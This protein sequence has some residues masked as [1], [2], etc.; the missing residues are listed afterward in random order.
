MAFRAETPM[1]QIFLPFLIIAVLVGGNRGA[2]AAALALQTETRPK[3]QACLK[4]GIFSDFGQTVIDIA[5]PVITRMYKTAG[6]CMEPIVLPS[7]RSALQLRAGQIDAEMFRTKQA[8]IRTKH[9][10]ILIPQPMFRTNMQISWIGEKPFSG[11]LKDLTGRSIGMLRG[12][13]S[14]HRLVSKYTDKITLLQTLEKGPELLERGRIDFLISDSVSL[15]EIRKGCEALDLAL[16]SK[17]FKTVDIFHVV[18]KRHADKVTRLTKALQSMIKNG[19]M[20][21]LDKGYGLSVPDIQ[22]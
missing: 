5:V 6:L 16:Q 2:N 7:R 3:E 20:D 9:P 14:I 21:G 8:I 4:V 19:E 22:D 17:S 11:S 12:Q 1:R 15:F 10:G 18:H 13:T